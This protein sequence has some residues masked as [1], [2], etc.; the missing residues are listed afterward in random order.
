MKNLL[1]MR[2]QAP[3]ITALIFTSKSMGTNSNHKSIYLICIYSIYLICIYIN[4]EYI[5]RPQLVQHENVATNLA[6][7]VKKSTFMKANKDVC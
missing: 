7:V 3:S 4:I 1:T 6:S 5:Y 2:K